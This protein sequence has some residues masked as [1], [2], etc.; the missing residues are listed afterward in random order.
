MNKSIYTDC[1]KKYLK[2]HFK[3]SR[4][5]SF[6]R[7]LILLSFTIFLILFLILLYLVKIV[8]PIIYS[9]GEANIQKLLVKSSNN[10]IAEVINSLA[11][12]DFVK[13]SYASNGDILAIKAETIK[14]N[15]VSNSLAKATQDEIDKASKL[16]LNISIGTCSGIGFL[17][18]K[19]G[20]I[21]LSIEPIGSASCNFYTSFEEA[22]IN[23]TNHKIYVEIETEASLILPFGFEKIRQSS[24]YLLAECVIIGKIPNI[25]LNN[26]NI[27]NLK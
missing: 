5:K 18:G 8:N 12:D 17:S 24:N 9:Y 13:I 26:S 1:E 25:Y 20:K 21:N 15:Q 7:K 19:G 11:Y 4:S 3:I 22:G 10:A 6:K 16:G 27:S 2:K 23:Q 14:I